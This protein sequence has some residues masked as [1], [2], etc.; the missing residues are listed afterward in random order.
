MVGSVPAAAANVALQPSQ[1]P[2][3]SPSSGSRQGDN[4]PELVGRVLDRWAYELGVHLHFI[5]PGKPVQNAFVESFNGKF[6]DQCLNEHWFV[7]P[8]DASRII[9]TF[10]RDYNT[11]S[12]HSSLGGLTRRI[13]AS[14]C[15]S[16]GA[17]GAFRAAAQ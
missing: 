6:R 12:P 7:D 2:R 8:A 13:P 14:G 3:S 5:D 1:L 4:G 15:S 9:E 16:R 11:Y 10:R 17:F